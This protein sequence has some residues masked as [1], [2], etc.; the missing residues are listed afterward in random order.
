VPD[1]ALPEAFVPADELPRNAA[2]KL[3]R[4]RLRADAATLFPGDDR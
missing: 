3:D 2:G 1:Y 4:A